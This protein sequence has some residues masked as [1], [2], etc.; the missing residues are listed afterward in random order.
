MK[1][2]MSAVMIASALSGPA[3]AA[4]PEKKCY[5]NKEFMKLIDDNALVT[6]YNGVTPNNKINEIM[7]SK[8][9]H[10][11]GVEYDR[12]TDGNALAAKNYCIYSIVDDVTFNDKSI[13]FLYNILEKARGQKT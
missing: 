7:L 3:L 5:E 2:I 8:D 6:L 9:R 4:G 11:Y 1:Y 13:E 10:I 12:A